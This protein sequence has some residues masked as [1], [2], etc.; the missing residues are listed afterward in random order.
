[1]SDDTAGTPDSS[2]SPP[3][4]GNGRRQIEQRQSRQPLAGPERRSGDRRSGADRRATS[5]AE[6][7]EA[8]ED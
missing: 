4:L 3:T 5:R 6:G 1:M 2:K 7:T 8:A